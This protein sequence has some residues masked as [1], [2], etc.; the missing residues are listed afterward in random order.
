AG[1]PPRRTRAIDADVARLVGRYMQAVVSEGTGRAAAIEGVRVA[2]KTGTA[3]L[4]DTSREDC[5]PSPGAPCPPV[6]DDPSDTDA[7][8]AAYAPA[9]EPRVA[10][11]VLLVQNGSGGETA[12]PVAKQVLQAALG[13]TPG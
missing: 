7:W 2:G 13:G 8:F 3:E 6:V 10:V 9:A 12:A 11:G 5:T 4:R 1:L